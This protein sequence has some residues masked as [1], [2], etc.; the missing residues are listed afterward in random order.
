MLK[1][2][3]WSL[4]I[5]LN[6]QREYSEVEECL[7][8]SSRPKSWCLPCLQPMATER[9]LPFDLIWNQILVSTVFLEASFLTGSWSV[10][11]T[12]RKMPAWSSS[13][14]C[15]Q[16]NTSMKMA[17]STETSRWSGRSAG[18]E[19]HVRKTKWT[20]W[21]CIRLGSRTLRECRLGW[22]QKAASALRFLMLIID[23]H[24]SATPQ[25]F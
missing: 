7:P 10:V 23:D 11:S 9:C 17:S 6:T 14:S 2:K 24:C 20:S 8:A 12:Q 5:I 19:M 1:P 16:W 15:Q 21:C 18:W 3:K 25:P 13:R 22:T 4:A